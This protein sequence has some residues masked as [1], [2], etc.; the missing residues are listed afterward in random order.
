MKWA[1]KLAF[2]KGSLNKIFITRD[3]GVVVITG[4]TSRPSDEHPLPYVVKKVQYG[5]CKK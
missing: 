5:V 2:L 3:K 4:S 1:P